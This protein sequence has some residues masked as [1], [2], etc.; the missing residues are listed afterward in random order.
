M[1]GK[2]CL[3]TGANAGIGKETAVGLA[4]QGARILMV[5]RDVRRGETARSD[6]RGR[7]AGAE[8]EL[9]QADLS[10]IA[11]VGT[12]VRDVASRTD[13]LDVLICNAGL[14]NTRRVMTADGL[15][16]TFSVN[17]LAPF[18][19]VN[20]LLDLLRRSQPAR[21]VVVASGAHTRGTIRFNDLQARRGYNGL[22]AYSQSKLANVLFAAELA[23]RLPAE[24]VTVNSIHPGVVATKLLLRG[25][26]PKW[27][28][29]P[30]TMSAEEGA[31]TSIYAASSPDLNGVSGRYFDDCREK[32]PS[33]EAQDRQ[34]AARLWT[35]SEKI[36]EEKIRDT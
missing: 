26:V 31:K 33:A 14:F 16:A 6:I 30:W 29:R 1:R 18:V 35:V 7:V 28:V 2:T 3:I 20:G 11:A 17:H 4:A 10:K 34:V 22:N 9:I 19:L 21:V 5:C 36:V 24:E 12:L 27:L 23:R 25:I 15:E 13:R 32:E 8:L